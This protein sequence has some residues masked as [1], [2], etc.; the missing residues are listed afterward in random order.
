MKNAASKY[1]ASILKL[2]QSFASQNINKEWEDKLKKFLASYLGIISTFQ[3]HY[4]NY[5]NGVSGLVKFRYSFDLSLVSVDST[6][7][8]MFQILNVYN[9]MFGASE[10]LDYTILPT[11]K[12]KE[13]EQ[14]IQ[15]KAKTAAD[16][17]V[18]KNINDTFRRLNAILVKVIKEITQS[19]GV[20]I[21]NVAHGIDV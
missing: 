6:V 9:Q 19:N 14:I 16:Y 17:S 4:F 15:Y 2:A 12:S 10:S 5:S 8:L 7:R 18:D 21:K 3:I 1:R 20:D 13:P 11:P